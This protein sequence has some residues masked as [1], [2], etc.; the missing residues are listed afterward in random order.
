VRTENAIV[1][2]LLREIEAG[3]TKSI[4]PCRLDETQMSQVLRVDALA[5][6]KRA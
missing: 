5:F 1:E 4:A 2:L 6:A 3:G